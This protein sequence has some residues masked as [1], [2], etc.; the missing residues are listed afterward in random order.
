MSLTRIVHSFSN[1]SNT[2]I[3][4]STR[5]SFVNKS[6][7]KMFYL[8]SRGQEK[9][10]LAVKGM[11][12]LVISFVYG[13]YLPWLLGQCG[14]HPASVQRALKANDFLYAFTHLGSVVHL[15]KY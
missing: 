5:Q 3:C 2:G 8:L 10:A 1:R 6:D 14:H 15:G 4:G 13:L 12:S 9:F 7:G 11:N